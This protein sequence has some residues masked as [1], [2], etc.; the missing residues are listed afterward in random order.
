MRYREQV[1]RS[2]R[3]AA[4][5]YAPAVGAVGANRAAAVAWTEGAAAEGADLIVL[6]ELASSGYVFND[7]SEAERASEETD[8]P[9]VTALGEVCACNDCYVVCG[10]NERSAT[11]RY[12]SAVLVGPSGLM[13]T[14][15][16]VHLFHDEQSWFSAGEDWSST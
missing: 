2:V 14:Y 4:A 13:A 1:S 3:V 8:G 10:L 7:D 16:K 6:P 15:R 11:A 9:L 5:Q 12:N